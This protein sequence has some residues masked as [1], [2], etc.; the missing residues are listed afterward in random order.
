ME[1]EETRLFE[2]L[3]TT[4][5]LLETT[6]LE[7]ATITLE[8]L[9]TTTTELLETLLLELATIT[10][11]LLLTTA[12]ELLDALLLELTATTLESAT[13][14]EPATLL[15]APLESTAMLDPGATELPGRA[16]EP[17]IA[18]LLLA[19]MDDVASPDVEYSCEDA[20]ASEGE[21]E[22]QTV[23]LHPTSKVAAAR[24]RAG[25]MD[26]MGISGS[27][28]SVVLSLLGMV[29]NNSGS[30]G[31]NIHLSCLNR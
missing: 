7:L 12:T 6:L 26:F 15:A 14:L 30:S 3:L 9:L 23:E 2:L 18:E 19:V 20:P 29:I 24:A 8:L 27:C 16:E 13:A 21:Q 4:T 17:M 1:E 22:S 10:L 31:W 11:E 28:T 5:E 25:F